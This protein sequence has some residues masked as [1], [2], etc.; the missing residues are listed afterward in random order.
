MC[1]SA[2]NG[3]HLLPTLRASADS[4][5]PRAGVC[6]TRRNVRRESRIEKALSVIRIQSSPEA[7]PKTDISSISTTPCHPIASSP[8]THRRNQ[9]GR[10]GRTRSARSSSTRTRTHTAGAAPPGRRGR[11]HR[12]Q[13]LRGDGR[14]RGGRSHRRQVDAREL[15]HGGGGRRWLS[16]AGRGQ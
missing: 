5:A 11:Q 12:F 3:T 1:M 16:W 4:V 14:L 10:H 8:N 13:S 15:A 7:R 2:T 9:H 6:T